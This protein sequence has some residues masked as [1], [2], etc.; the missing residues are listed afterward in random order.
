MKTY[1]EQIA[2]AMKRTIFTEAKAKKMRP[3]KIKFKDD[4][5]WVDMYR[6]IGG[7]STFNYGM[8]F[9]AVYESDESGV[10]AAESAFKVDLGGEYQDED[11]FNYDERGSGITLTLQPE[12]EEFLASKNID[13]NRG[14][15]DLV[16]DLKES[17]EMWMDEYPDLKFAKVS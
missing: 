11:I 16:S 14:R 4:R 10:D 9:F 3:I 7:G 8:V 2:E 5:I 6:N 15:K 1:P 12:F 13:P 17:L